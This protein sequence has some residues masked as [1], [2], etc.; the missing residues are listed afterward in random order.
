MTSMVEI[1][2]VSS[3]MAVGGG[4]GRCALCIDVIESKKEVDACVCIWVSFVG[5]RGDPV[6]CK[7]TRRKLKLIEDGRDEGEE[8]GMSNE[9]L[10]ICL[11][12]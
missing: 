12:K 5:L 1:Q 11:R 6:N 3:G 2:L 9:G 10:A 4:G 7:T 8:Y